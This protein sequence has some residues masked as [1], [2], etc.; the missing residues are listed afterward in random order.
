MN[1]LHHKNWQRCQVQGACARAIKVSN[2]CHTGGPTTQHSTGQINHKMS[3]HWNKHSTNIPE[4]QLEWRIKTTLNLFPCQFWLKKWKLSN[5]ALCRI[6]YNQN[7]G[8]GL[9]DTPFH[10]LNGCK[11]NIKMKF[12]KYRHDHILKD[13][14]DVIKHRKEFKDNS[15]ELNNNDTNNNS[16]NTYCNIIK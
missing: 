9:I 13:I 11:S 8:R 3:F 5:H 7:T 4:H 15:Q 14:S 1:Y 12:Y 2:P 10:S 16:N 6:C